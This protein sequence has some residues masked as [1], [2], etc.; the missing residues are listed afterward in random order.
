MNAITVYER[1]AALLPREM[2]STEFRIEA[3]QRLLA[4]R[5][6]AGLGQKELADRAQAGITAARL[7]RAERGRAELTLR[8]LVAV[9]RVLEDATRPPSPPAPGS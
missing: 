5:R 7:S 6:K 3:G 8:Q 9:A 4:A 1:A 2:P